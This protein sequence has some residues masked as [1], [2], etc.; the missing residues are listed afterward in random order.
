MAAMERVASYW[1]S[2]YNILE[3]SDLDAMV[4]DASYMKGVLGR[5]KVV[6]DEEYISSWA[7][8]CS[9]DN[10]ST[11]RRRFGESRRGNTFLAST[12]VTRAHS[13]VKNKQLYSYAQFMRISAYRG[14]KRTYIDDVSSMLITINHIL[15][16]VAVFKNLGVN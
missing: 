4:V 5:K 1:K 9:G 12:L 15:K 14:K 13:A 6:K 7:G 10:E 3:Y 11:K 16:D 8:L 2:L